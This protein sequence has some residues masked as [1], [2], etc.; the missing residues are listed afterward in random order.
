MYQSIA[1]MPVFLSDYVTIVTETEVVR[2]WRE[3]LL[4]RPW[5]P[6]KKTK[7]VSQHIPSEDV[8]EVGGKL[9]MHPTTYYK[10]VQQLPKHDSPADAP[11]F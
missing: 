8:Y 9:I 7:T 11:P 1:G 2:T 4:T 10:L 3:R 6:L 5:Q